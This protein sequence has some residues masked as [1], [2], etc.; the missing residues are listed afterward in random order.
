MASD[1][2]PIVNL[3]LDWNP[4]YEDDFRAGDNFAADG[5]N[6][7]WVQEDEEKPNLWSKLIEANKKLQVLFLRASG[8]TDIDLSHISS[9][10]K[11]NTTIKVLDVSSNIGLSAPSVDGL[12]E[13][14]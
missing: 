7:L 9:I 2:C 1:S 5:S 4:I 13:L 10:M 3:F 11:V 8:L 12:I 6:K 14:L